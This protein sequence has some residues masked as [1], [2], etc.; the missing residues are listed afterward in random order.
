MTLEWAEL[1]K[2]LA[3]GLLM[4]LTQ[5]LGARKRRRRMTRSAE[6]IEAKLDFLCETVRVV[7]TR[8]DRI[9]DVMGFTPT[10]ARRLRVSGGGEKT[11]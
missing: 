5:L 3:A 11:S 6:R 9:E 7:Q 10:E 2:P 4:G 1:A 8:L